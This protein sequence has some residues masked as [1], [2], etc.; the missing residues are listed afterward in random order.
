M[1]RRGLLHKFADRA[2]DAGLIACSLT[3]AVLLRF[4]FT[5]PLVLVP[6]LKKALLVA[7]VIKLPILD[8]AGIHRRPRRYAGLSDLVRLGLANLAASTVFTVIIFLSVGKNF[9]RSI[10]FLDAV[11]CCCLLGFAHFSV[12]LYTEA[13]VRE[14]RARR[15]KR[16]IVYGAGSAGVTLVREIQS[17]G[18]G[19]YEVAGFLDDDPHKRDAI[20]VG[21][22]VLGRG[23]DAASVV[24]RFEHHK[25]PIDEI[26]IAMPGTKGERLREAIT[27][28]RTAKIPCRTVPGI[29]EVLDGK[30]LFT[31]IRDL[32]FADLLGREAV[33]LDESPIRSSI[34]N[35]NLLI[36][37]SAGSIGSELCRQVARFDPGRLV[38]FDQ[39]ESELFKIDNELRQ[40]FPKL[41]IH[42]VVGD[43]RDSE[44]LA[45]VIDTFAISS[46]FH[47]AAY[48]HVPMMEDQPLEAVQNNILG[49]WNLLTAV[50]HHSVPN[51]LM[52]STDN[53]FVSFLS[54]T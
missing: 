18:Q 5:I 46:V 19:S 10:Y 9:P 41:R 22:P 8:F 47:A 48:K 14:N 40:N 49:T 51:F 34:A 44:R 37:G 42:S 27:K 26:V 45:R 3:G 50:R 15:R 23:R 1:K 43:I 33:Q 24:D 4:D 6:I 7:L 52:I 54:R 53:A 12:R 38:L 11:L 21:V 36:T 30:V 32:S 16:V 31:Q 13:I 35:R 29:D 25:T 20:I 17:F 2:C 39:A 28:C